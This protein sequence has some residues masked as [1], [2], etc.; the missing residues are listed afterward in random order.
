MNKEWKIMTVTKLH[1]K[2]NT[3]DIDDQQAWIKPQEQMMI[4]S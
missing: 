1:S 2:N 4:V 3:V